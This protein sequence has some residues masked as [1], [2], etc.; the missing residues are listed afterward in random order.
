[1][2]SQDEI[3]T[4]P[5]FFKDD[6]RVTF[7]SIELS[8]GDRAELVLAPERPLRDPILFMSNTQKESTIAVEQILH[9]KTAIF[10]REKLTLDQLRYGKATGLTITENEP[11]KIIVINTSPFKTTVGAS[12]VANEK[13]QDSTYSLSSDQLA[14]DKNKDKE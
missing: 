14:K 6:S 7:E 10:E 12:L 4:A 5:V 8:P 1:M 2:K 11:I 9:G 3:D 13:A